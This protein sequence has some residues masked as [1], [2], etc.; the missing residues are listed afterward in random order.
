MKSFWIHG[1]CLGLIGWLMGCGA[2][3]QQPM[4]PQPA[5][6]GVPT[7]GQEALTNLPG[8]VEPT[9]AA[10]YKFR[11]QTGQY[12]PSEN[13]AS[14]STAVPQGATS[15]MVRILQET[16][17]FRVLERENLGNLLNERKIIRSTRAEFAQRQGTAAEPLPPLLFAGV[18][19]EGGIIAYDANIRTGGAGARYFGT[20]ASGQYRE[21]R[22]TVYLRMVSTSNGEVLKTVYAS[23]S[24]LSQAVDVGVFRYVSFKRLLEVETGFTYNEPSEIAVTEA[25]EKAVYSLI[26]EGMM[27]GFWAASDA[28]AQT[29]AIQQYLDEQ[30]E[31]QERDYLGRKQETR[32]DFWGFSAEAQGWRYAGDYVG[33]LNRPAAGLALSYLPVQHR[34]MYS[35]RAQLGSLAAGDFYQQTLTSVEGRFT[36]FMLPFD[37]FSPFLNVGLGIDIG[38]RMYPK[39]TSG[40]GAEFMFRQRLGLSVSMQ[41]HYLFSDQVD[42]M[43]H[44]RF[45]DYY[46]NLSLGLNVYFSSR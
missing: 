35:L 36:W 6:L 21:D 14:W 11:D 24:I 16:G 30:E 34:T 9:I 31:N 41:N 2:Y 38:E 13:G 23:K 19:L 29:R 1:V 17:W 25:I 28:E 12:R 27:D 5:R 46:W 37:R 44:G 32:R 10:V 42:G 22:V 39:V 40:V 43:D 45:N 7:T 26:V 18:I 20:G 3:L 8:P 33:A 4:Q 15:I